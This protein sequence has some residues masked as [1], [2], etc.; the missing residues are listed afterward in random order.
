MKEVVLKLLIVIDL[1]FLFVDLEAFRNMCATYHNEVK[2]IDTILDEQPLGLFYIKQ[3]RL[4]E[5]ATPEPN[6]LI[7]I[8]EEV[9]PQYCLK[10]IDYNSNLF[11]FCLELEGKKLTD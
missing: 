2:L 4:K 9:M 11:Y 10:I 6:R 8:L 3:Q 7:G 5:T 1:S